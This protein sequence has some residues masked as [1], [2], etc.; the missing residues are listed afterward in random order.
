MV[1]NRRLVEGCDTVGHTDLRKGIQKTASELVF[2]LTPA[3]GVLL[4]GCLGAGSKLLNPEKAPAVLARFA[5][6]CDVSCWLGSGFTE[7][8]STLILRGSD[9]F[10]SFWKA[11]LSWSFAAGFE[12]TDAGAGVSSLSEP[13]LSE[14]A[15]NAIAIHY[16]VFFKPVDRS[17]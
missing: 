17:G 13:S 14:Y 15:T 11:G 3:F 7:S 8:S 6:G 4:I 5:G 9:A 10:V 12:G 2:R 16:E 1:Q